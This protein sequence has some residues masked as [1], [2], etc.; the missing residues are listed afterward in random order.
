MKKLH[1]ILGC[2]AVAAACTGEPFIPD[3]TTGPEVPAGY[4]M[5]TLLAGYPAET[6]TSFDTETGSFAWTDG[7][8]LAFHLS[9]GSYLVNPVDPVTGEV[10][11]IIRDGIVRNQFAVYPAGA[12]VPEHAEAGDLMVS[13]PDSYD[14][15][16]DL[17]SDYAPLPMVADND[18]ALDKISFNHVGALL[19]INLKVRA[20][21]RQVRVSLG[22]RI[23]GNFAV[24]EG[25]DGLLTTVSDR[26]SEDGV[27]FII[28]RDGL[29]ADE[30]VKLLLPV[31]AGAYERLT[32]SI[33]NGTEETDRFEKAVSLD[34]ARASGKK[35]SIKES[36]FDD[37]RDYFWI[38][39][40]DAGSTVRFSEG[41]NAPVTLFVSTDGKRTFREWDKS[42]LVLEQAGDRAYFYGTTGTF[43]TGYYGS[44]ISQF[45]GT[46]RLKVGGRLSTL[47]A[48]DGG[49]LQTACF[50]SLFARNDA[51]VDASELIMPDETCPNCFDTMFGYC[52]NLLHGPALPTLHITERCYQ[53]MFSY[54]PSLA[55][56][57]ALP[58]TD[59]AEECYKF[60][61]LKCTSL[62]KAPELP[63][64]KMV[65]YCYEGMFD[66][67]ASLTEAP[68]LPSVDLANGCYSSMFGRC[69]SL[70]ECPVLPATVLFPSCYSRMFEESGIRVPPLLPAPVM[71]SSCYYGMFRNCTS[72][73]EAPVLASTELAKTCYFD[74]LRGTPIT[75]APV[76]PAT[77]MAEGCYEGMFSWC[78]KLKSGPELP[79]LSLAK[80]CYANMFGSSALT[81]APA[82]P[83]TEL[84]E[85][86]Y[87]SMFNACRSLKAM[88]E[89]PAETVVTR[90][91]YAMFKECSSLTEAVVPA[92][93]FTGTAG[94]QEMFNFCRKLKKITFGGTAWKSGVF[95][96]WVGNVAETGEFYKKA[97]LE[98]VF[99]ADAIPNGWDVYRVEDISAEL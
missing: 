76:L 1:L 89:L 87:S 63:A 38:E 23:T 53:S 31:P 12:A 6:R 51:L 80:R 49:S 37:N 40:L 96:S 34:F 15:S 92:K 10:H 19:Q 70:T 78:K 42:E 81:V 64:V 8:L 25:E 55:E 77:V 41:A 97:S 67:C 48:R 7:D 56:A 24:S 44:W 30:E 99:G 46:G 54:C 79:S 14:I 2:A 98:T 28:S 94:C 72:L 85:G 91:Y 16:D 66:G 86:C 61:F 82:L 17:S 62:P 20:G 84:A 4:H 59:L 68:A 26:G 27:T 3:A 88:P 32:L 90:S 57:P 21:A 83:A 39:A 58:A 60:M 43:S 33:G 11:L 22:R 13:Y 52:K 36:S 35:I 5:E 65:K 9:D 93:Y 95:K 71:V 50:H 69:P 74:M 75:V 47:L 73:K 45:G 29:P 18:P